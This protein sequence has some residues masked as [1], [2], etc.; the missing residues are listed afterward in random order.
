MTDPVII[1]CPACASLN[2]VPRDRLAGG[3]KCG[4]CHSP[5]FTSYPLTLTAANFEVHAARSG[6]PLLVDFWAAWCGPCRQMAPQF[7]AAAADLEPLVRL[8]KVD[9]EA[10][11]VIAG[12]YAIRSIPTLILISDG[13]EL[14]RHSGAMSRSAIVNWVWQTLR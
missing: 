1:A 6:I 9:T 5:L 3:G 14:A 12:R 10:E 11:Q 8:G 4:R 7:E 13:R 2:R